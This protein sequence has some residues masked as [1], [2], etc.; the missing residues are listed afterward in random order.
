MTPNEIAY[1]TK[2]HQEEE[3]DGADVLKP[4]S[5]GGPRARQGSVHTAQAKANTK[6]N[7]RKHT[8]RT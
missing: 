7:R 5:T 1:Q 4:A 8:K 6:R 3:K 2:A